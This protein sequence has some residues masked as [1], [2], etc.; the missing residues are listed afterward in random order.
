[1]IFGR[2]VTV[3]YKTTCF[4]LKEIVPYHRKDYSQEN[5]TSCFVIAEAALL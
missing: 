4:V 5:K 1:M 2:K 3:T